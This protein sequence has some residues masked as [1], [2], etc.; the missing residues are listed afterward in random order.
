MIRGC[1]RNFYFVDHLVH[2]V[3]ALLEISKK[4]VKVCY[5]Y[6]KFMAIGHYISICFKVV[7][8]FEKMIHVY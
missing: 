7:G 4:S 1:K 5:K 6:N 3:Y 2:N 8:I